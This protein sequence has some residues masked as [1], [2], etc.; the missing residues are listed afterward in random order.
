M[1]GGVYT[2]GLSGARGARMTDTATPAS[3]AADL[4]GRPGAG[5]Q[6]SEQ[7]GEA[8]A[9]R[10]RSRDV[11]PLGRLLPYAWNHKGHALM[12]GLWLILSTAASL[13]LTSAARV[14]QGGRIADSV[15]Y[16]CA[17]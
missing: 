9:R 7:I 16:D 15:T 6:L 2:E 12:A 17:P 1:S 13:G 8:G 10:K 14:Q 3:D 4:R 5:A 11:R